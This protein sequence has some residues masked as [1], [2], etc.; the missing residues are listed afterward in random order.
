MT[1]PSP[2][3][4]PSI[5]VT[6]G[7]DGSFRVNGSA[8]APNATVNIRVAHADQPLL[9]NI[10]FNTTASPDGKVQDFPTGNVCRLPGGRIA[11]SARDGR[12]DPVDHSAL[13]SNF[14]TTTCPLQNP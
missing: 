2:V 14:V 10:L 1:S 12:I 8:F 6:S 5:S 9:T 4:K 13:V 11:F 7:G 3:V